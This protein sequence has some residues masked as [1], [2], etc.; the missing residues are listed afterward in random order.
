MKIQINSSK[1]LV[2]AKLSSNIESQTHNQT[3]SNAISPASL[4]AMLRKKFVDIAKGQF[5]KN[6]S[7]D[8][9]ISNK[10]EQN[11]LKYQNYLNNLRLINSSNNITPFNR[12][13]SADD[14]ES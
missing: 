1:Y 2:E 5:D 3:E 10:I 9:E 7:N 8:S 11:E 6:E 14:L 13:A 12:K 4:I